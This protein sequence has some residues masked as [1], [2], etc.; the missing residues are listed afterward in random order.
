M[1]DHTSWITVY[2]EIFL[3]GMAFVIMMADLFVKSSSRCFTYVL[4]LISLGA[5]AVLQMLYAQGGFTLYGFS[6]MVVSDPMGNWLKCFA[7]I[8]LMITLVYARPYSEDRGMLRGGELFTLSMFALFGMFVMISGNNFL[9]LYLGLECLTLSSYALVALRRDHAVS[10][11][12]A[13]KYFVLGA[14][15]S[16]FLLYGISMLYGATS[17]L[18]IG[19]VFRAIASGHANHQVL[20]FGLVFVVAGLAFKLGLVPF[21][22][23]L[24]DVYQGAP[25]AATLLIGGAPKLAAFGMMMRIL[26]EGLLPLAFDWQQMLAFMAIASLLVGNLAAVMQTNLKRML[27]FSTISQMGFVSLGMLAGVVNG[28]T[29]AAANA[30]SSAMFYV[31]TYVLTTL[32]T[33]GVIMLLARE[34]FESEEIADFAGLNQRSPLYAA[35]MSVCLFSLAGIP[36]MVG[37]YAKLSVLQALVASQDKFLI[38]LAVYAVMMSLIGAFYYIRVIKVMY[39]DNPITATTVTA[40]KDVRVVLSLNGLLVLVLGILPGGLMTLCAQAIVKT[41]GT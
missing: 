32:A 37:F 5:L 35:V 4:T 25:T 20:V 9:V 8:A 7:T 23:W 33:F 21:H 17:T 30:Y 6:N 2:P 39:F 1:I 10:T 3:L 31:I 18:D 14:M 24:P 22:M 15:A 28:N 12:A 36:P 40:G 29:L 41:L 34:G 19:G 13:M 27:A 26:V 11:E 16:G 38:G